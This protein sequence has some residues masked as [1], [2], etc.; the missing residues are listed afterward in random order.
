M[1]PQFV[2]TATSP[3]Q[4]VTLRIP[5]G[6]DQSLHFRGNTWRSAFPY[7]FRCLEGGIWFT[8]ESLSPMPFQCLLNRLKFSTPTG[9]CVQIAA[10]P[11]LPACSSSTVLIIY[12]LSLVT[13]EGI[14]TQF[15]CQFLP[16]RTKAVIT[17]T[18]AKCLSN[19]WWVLLNY[20]I[21]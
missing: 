19:L 6:P 8:S 20:I 7:R 18:F 4:Q 3:N 16:T 17:Q 1:R 10:A 5:S 11:I 15:P 2:P 12:S 9:S 13:A 21:I 14:H